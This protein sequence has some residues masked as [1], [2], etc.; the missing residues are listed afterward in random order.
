M[1]DGFGVP[2]AVKFDSRGR[3]HVV[4]Q[5]AGEILRVD[6]ETGDKEVIATIMPG[7]DNL[8]FDSQDRLFVSHAQDGSIFEVLPGGTTRTVSRG[9]MIAPG[10]VAVLPRPH[11]GESVFVADLWSLREFNGRTGRPKSVEPHNLAVP[12]GITSPL[13]VSP[14]GDNL[15]LSSWIGNAVQVWNPEAGEVLENYPDFAVPLNAIRFQGDLVVAELGTGSVVRR[16][17]TTGER[18]TLAEGLYVPAGLA[19]TDD[20]LW[21]GDWA[22]GIVW[23]IVANGE[24]IEPI[25]VAMDLLFPEGLA[26]DR[27]GSLLVVETGAGRLSRIDP[28]TGEV[29]AVA[30]GL[31]LGA[32]GI[33]EAA[34]PTWFFNG[35]AVGPSGVIYVTGDI[36]NVLYRFRPTR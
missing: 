17:A 11:R 34:P 21:V 2:A 22:T 33:P 20:D 28:A 10:G 16:N 14:D 6:T 27:D 31:A 19:A 26:V 7:L 30:E 32:E 13:T 12:G 18:V 5:L 35:V 23:Q 4:D 25:L 8:A 9:G 15:V 36:A 3:L 29:N 1:A 24:P